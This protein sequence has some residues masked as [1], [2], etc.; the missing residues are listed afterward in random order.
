MLNHRYYNKKLCHIQLQ[1]S[2]SLKRMN[3]FIN[4]EELDPESVIRDPTPSGIFFHEHCYII[5]YLVVKW[6]GTF[7]ISYYTVV[8]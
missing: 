1:V 6:Q 3:K 2:V 4:S 5:C 8:I 7:E